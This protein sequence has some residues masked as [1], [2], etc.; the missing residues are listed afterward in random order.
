MFSVASELVLGV[1]TQNVLHGF[2]YNKAED[3]ACVHKG[4][5]IIKQQ[6]KQKTV[7]SIEPNT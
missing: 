2:P 6:N 4:P 7:Q 5:S 3:V 1:R